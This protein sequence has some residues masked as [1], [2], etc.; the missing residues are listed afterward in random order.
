MSWRL[1][2]IVA[3]IGLSTLA[4][5]ARLFQLQVLDHPYYAAE[6]RQTRLREETVS[7]RRGSILDTNGYPLVISVDSY[8]VMVEKRAWSEPALAENAA[9]KLAEIS[10]I[11]PREAVETVINSQAYES[12]VARGL[13]YE[14]ASQVREAR[15]PGV[16]LLESSHR[17]YP[18]GS[19][20]AQLIGFL[21]RDGQGLTGLE[22]DM[23]KVLGG[24]KGEL[25]I[26][27]DGLGNDLFFGTRDET[28]PEPGSD[29]VLTIDRYIQRL[30]ERELSETI[31]KHEATGGSIIVL[32]AQTGA[33][34]AMAS[35]PS[36]DL[37]NPDLS[38]QSKLGLFRNRAITDQYEPGSVF[39]L[40]TVAAALD[41]GLVSPGTWWND[42]G[43]YDAGGWKIY[44]WDFSANGSQTV[45]QLIAKSLNTGAAWLSSL[46]GPERFYDYV[47]RFGFAQPTGVNLSGEVS[48]QVR[49][50]QNDS[51]WR[52]VDLA[53]NSFGQGLTATPLQMAMV[54]AAIAND[55]K[56]MKPYV[57][58][59]IV[60]DKQR[61]RIE[62]Q[63]LGQVI[64]AK[65]AQNV[66]QI[67]GVVVSGIPAYLLDVPR[68]SLGGKTGTAN[69][70]QGDGVYKPDSYISSFA[71]VAPLG[72]PR[73][74]VLVKIDEPKGVPWGT[75]VAA[76]AFG[77]IMK[78]ALAY[79]NIPP[80]KE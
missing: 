45:T 11:N 71:G 18:E 3:I 12:A 44:N 39:K 8:D 17:V 23:E 32:D 58:E 36:F 69:I 53:T 64:S 38:D 49:T 70:A 60:N 62:P 19:L 73:L 22:A 21:G 80:D 30:A 79:Y 56:L 77:K 41:A 25:V 29:I 31:K 24:S 27:K 16:R 59:E 6:A 43:V 20:A 4:V 7:S 63:V 74:V 34:R 40:V 78:A 33:I 75:T 67:M 35:Q 55:G 1:G 42:T 66:K 13:N 14:Q 61:Q 76:P 72:N 37:T 50:P 2:V 9:R 48:G 5:T 28:A 65:T 68:Y 54:V 26:E 10:G 15:L 52:P 47:H 57:V 46:L 51:D